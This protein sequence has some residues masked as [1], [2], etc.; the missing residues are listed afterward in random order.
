[1]KDKT[2]EERKAIAA[3]SV[4]TRKANR[5]REDAE[6]EEY[7]DYAQK[8]RFGIIELEGKLNRLREEVIRE[9][10]FREA[11]KQLT[12]NVLLR[13]HEIVEHA[14]PVGTACGIYFLV[15]EKKVVYVGQS[16]NIFSRVYT[17][18]Q[19]KQFDSYVYIP[20]DRSILDKMESLYIHF[21]S[22]PL[23]GNLHN[24]NKIAP[25]QLETLLGQQ[26]K[27]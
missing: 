12:S 21:L 22:P 23:N 19:S 27:K 5:A 7:R 18:T 20:C 4:A 10:K 17:H 9:V 2:P 24:G 16:T 15:F 1:M 3:K 14:I 11:A 8:L 25:L 6:E 13:E 26:E